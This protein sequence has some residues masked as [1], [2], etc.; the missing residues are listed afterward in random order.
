M[1]L[2]AVALRSR[3][4]NLPPGT[5]W[6]WSVIL[7]AALGVFLRLYRS[8]GFTGVGFDEN[9]YR[10][11]VGA[12]SKVGLWNYPA[13]VES[14][15]EIQRGLPG[16]ILPPLRFLYIGVS[17]LWSSIS[18]AEPL[19]ALHDV[20]CAFSI[21]T[22]GVACCF[23]LRLAGRGAA[24]GVL[25]LM[26]CS[27]MQIHMS[28]HALVDGF[29]AFWALLSLWLLWENLRQPNH[30][31][32]LPAFGLSLVFMV[33]T[34]ENAAFVYVAL[35]ALVG[36]NRWLHFGKITPRLLAVMVAGPAL[37]VA[38]L[39]LLAGGIG[40]FIGCYQLSVSKNFTLAYAIQT[41]DGP[42]YRYLVDLLLIS[43]IVLVLALGQA[44]QIARARKEQ[45]FLLVF[46]AASYLVMCNLTYAMNLRY[47]TMWDMALRLLAFWWLASLAAKAGRYQVAMLSAAVLALCLFDLRQ[48][49]IFFVEH[50]LY[51]LVSEDLLR[52][53]KILK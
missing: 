38:L 45:W 3:F 7:T 51:E 34:K 32:W 19:I 5:A 27:P 20:A 10:T 17:Y 29:F 53:V 46:I 49:H 35:L 15:M 22:L 44:L 48:Y 40:N 23:T 8:A 50:P 1:T 28:Q 14:Y 6:R 31:V 52:S 41:G 21:A 47:A 12:V 39:I 43:P 2:G 18:G 30:R 42:W 4:D 11:Y 33:M 24:L 37:G 26:A 16:S 36:A 25:A 13:I 9:L